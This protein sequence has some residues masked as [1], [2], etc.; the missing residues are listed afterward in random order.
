[1]RA[2]QEGKKRGDEAKRR[3]WE[4]GEDEDDGMRREGHDE[5]DEA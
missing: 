2:V 3:S 4:G 5:G 1:M